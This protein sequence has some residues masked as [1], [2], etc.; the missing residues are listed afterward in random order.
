M[1]HKVCKWCKNNPGKI[2]IFGTILSFLIAAFIIG[3]IAKEKMEN[4]SPE[5]V[6]QN[7]RE[8]VAGTCDNLDNLTKK[9]GVRNGADLDTEECVLVTQVNLKTSGEDI[10]LIGE[11]RVN[12]NEIWKNSDVF[13]SN[14][15]IK[16]AEGKI[17]K[18][19]YEGKPIHIVDGH[20]EGVYQKF[21]QDKDD[22]EYSE[23]Q[24]QI[25]NARLLD[26][27]C[28]PGSVQMRVWDGSDPG[29]APYPIRVIPYYK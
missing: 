7:H 25:R 13:G 2:I 10:P 16:E 3:F 22:S 5:E 26:T 27:S 23:Q 14:P 24:K 12:V 11:Y 17:Q 4:M 29:R 1:F 21:P 18:L 8:Q 15:V 20:A 28:E 9:S 19:C 6:A